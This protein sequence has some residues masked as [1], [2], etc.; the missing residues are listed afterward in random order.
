[1]E[2]NQLPPMIGLQDHVIRKQNA[3]RLVPPTA[4][5]GVSN[6]SRSGLHYDFDRNG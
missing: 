1:M 5:Y 4:E 3:N 2:I 6:A